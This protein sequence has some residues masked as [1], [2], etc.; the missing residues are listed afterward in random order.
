M[1]L[2]QSYM[3]LYR[4]TLDHGQGVDSIPNGDSHCG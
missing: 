1:E 2:Y 3:N 4:D